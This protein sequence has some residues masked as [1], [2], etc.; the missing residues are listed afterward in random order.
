MKTCNNC[1]YEDCSK[2]HRYP[3]RVVVLHDEGG[4]ARLST[5]WPD[6]FNDKACGEFEEKTDENM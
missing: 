2:C 6:V 4:I 5:E 1:K 3:P